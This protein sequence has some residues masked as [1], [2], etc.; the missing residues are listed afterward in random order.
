MRTCFTALIPVLSAACAFGQGDGPPWTVDHC[1]VL[2]PVLPAFVCLE[3]EHEYGT[4]S[5]MTA[6]TGETWTMTSPA[7]NPPPGFNRSVFCDFLGFNLYWKSDLTIAGDVGATTCSEIRL[8]NGAGQSV[9]SGSGGPGQIAISFFTS[10]LVTP[11]LPVTLT[12][13]WNESGTCYADCNFDCQ[14]TVADFGCFQA[15]Y[16][17]GNMYADCNGNGVLNI[18]DFGC[19]QTCYVTCR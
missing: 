11:A 18:A 3:G 7:P 13:A 1:M 6:Q 2:G 16:V 19:F 15:K 17:L 5:V 8:L 12:I 9:G 10:E 14:L 4:T